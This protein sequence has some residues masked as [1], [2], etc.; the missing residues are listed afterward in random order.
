MITYMKNNINHARTLTTAIAIC[1]FS[2]VTSANAGGVYI[3]FGSEHGAPTSTYAAAADSPGTWNDITA[4]G[5]TIALLDIDGVDTGLSLNLTTAPP[6]GSHTPL[7]NVLIDDNFYVGT[8]VS[9]DFTVSGLA[10]GAYD[11]YYYAPTNVSVSTGPFTVEGVSASSL[12]GAT[13]LIEGVSWAKIENVILSDGSMDFVSTSTTGFRG[14]AGVQ[15]VTAVPEPS[16][17]ALLSLGGFAL[18]LRRRK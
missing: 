14:I 6:V 1:I 11:V 10:S 3:D 18:M 13:S 4:T 7:S 9:W 15:I 17:T 5:A 12:A 16:A 8:G 2:N